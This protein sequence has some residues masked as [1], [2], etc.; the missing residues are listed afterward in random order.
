[1]CVLCSSRVLTGHETNEDFVALGHDIFQYFGLGCRSVSKIYVPEGYDFI[2]FIDALAVHEAVADHTKY[3]NNYDY[4]KALLLINKVHHL[5]SGFLLI[6]EDKA[7]VSPISVLF[8]ETYSDKNELKNL[9]ELHNSE[10]QCIVAAPG[11]F[12]NSI[13]FGAAQCPALWDYPDGVDTLDFLLHQ[14]LNS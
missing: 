10:L 13:P 4:N 5:D 1:M 14:G 6:K 2:P 8:Y 9:L 7:M 12:Q 3:R 11:I